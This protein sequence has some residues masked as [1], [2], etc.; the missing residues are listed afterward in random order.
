MVLF[1]LALQPLEQSEHVF[2]DLGIPAGKLQIVYDFPLTIDTF[3]AL[4]DVFHVRS[5]TL[6]EN[7]ERRSLRNLGRRLR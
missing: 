4:L 1:E 3:A 7:V 2:V 5:K 6:L